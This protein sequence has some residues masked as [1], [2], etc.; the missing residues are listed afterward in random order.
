MAEPIPNRDERPDRMFM[1]TICGWLYREERGIPKADIAPATRWED[2]S[3]DFVC[4][5]CGA[6][7]DWFQQLRIGD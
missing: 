5:E 4:P 6:G 7:K 2:V 1:C 3:R